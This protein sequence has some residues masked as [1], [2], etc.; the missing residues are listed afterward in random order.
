MRTA[1]K[2]VTCSQ[3]GIF[4]F[5]WLEILQVFQTAFISCFKHGCA[6]ESS[7][8]ILKKLQGRRIVTWLTD[9]LLTGRYPAEGG[10]HF[11]TGIQAGDVLRH[12]HHPL[13]DYFSF[14]HEN[15]FTRNS[16]SLVLQHLQLFCPSSVVFL[17]EVDDILLLLGLF[18]LVKNKSAFRNASL[19]CKLFYFLSYAQRHSELS[20]FKCFEGGHWKCWYI[21]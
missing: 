11:F 17:W 3:Q 21:I 2:H 10:P 13:R 20:W 1:D 4:A 14:L 5:L 7:L 19:S 15:S 6:V 16:P 12:H 9:L 8:V 18:P